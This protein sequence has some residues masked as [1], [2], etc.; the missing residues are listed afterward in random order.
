MSEQHR[1]SE[2]YSAATKLI[3]AVSKT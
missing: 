2:D 1:L 3:N